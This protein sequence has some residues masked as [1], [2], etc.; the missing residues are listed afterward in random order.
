[1]STPDVEAMVSDYFSR[2][3]RALAPRPRSRRNQLIDDLRE[4]VAS[5]RAGLADESEASVRE[6]LD[7]LGP[8]G[9]IAA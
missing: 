6:I 3:K 7:P 4:R 9:D 2:L 8:P 1:V 5:A